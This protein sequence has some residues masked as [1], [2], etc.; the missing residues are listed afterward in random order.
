M[1]K[2]ELKAEVEKLLNNGIGN[3]MISG[4]LMQAT[5]MSRS[6]ALAFIREIQPQKPMSDADRAEYNALKQLN[7]ELDSM[8]IS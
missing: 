4:M 8:D 6:E 5:G 1:N 3:F 2:A 7:R